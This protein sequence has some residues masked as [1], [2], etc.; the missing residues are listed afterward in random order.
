MTRE[1][2]MNKIIKKWGMYS[3]T[4][5]WFCEIAEDQTISDDMVECAFVCAD[6]FPFELM[7]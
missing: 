6:T 2:M 5:I 3:K 4:T 7:E 1:E